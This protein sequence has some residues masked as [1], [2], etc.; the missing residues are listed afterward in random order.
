MTIGPGILIQRG[1]IDIGNGK[2]VDYTMKLYKGKREDVLEYLRQ[3]EIINELDDQ[4]KQDNNAFWDKPIEL[5]S[6]FKNNRNY[7]YI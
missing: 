7:N 6:Q 1:K 3:T 2:Q 5:Q 4:K